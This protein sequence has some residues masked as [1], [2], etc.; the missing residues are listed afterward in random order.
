VSGAQPADVF[1]AALRSAWDDA[2]APQGAP[3]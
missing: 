2:A 3:A 1:L